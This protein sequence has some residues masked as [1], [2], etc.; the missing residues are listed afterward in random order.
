MA[1]RPVI[2]QTAA[3][4]GRHIGKA[5]QPFAVQ[6]RIR[7]IDRCPQVMALGQHL[8]RLLLYFAV[9]GIIDLAAELTVFAGLPG[10]FHFDEYR[11]VFEILST[12]RI[13]AAWFK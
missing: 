1:G 4:I 12:R 3:N 7:Q 8:K 6:D 11:V 5:A 2:F 10:Q 13:I 9:I